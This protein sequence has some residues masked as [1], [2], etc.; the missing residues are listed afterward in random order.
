MYSVLKILVWQ[1]SRAIKSRLWQL[2]FETDS[3]GIKSKRIQV[4]SVDVKQPMVY[5]EAFGSIRVGST[6]LLP[7]VSELHVG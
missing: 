7:R 5:W 4:Y 1:E 6:V 3:F 2:G